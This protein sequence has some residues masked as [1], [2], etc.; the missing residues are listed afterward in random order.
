MMAFDTITGPSPAS[1]GAQKGIAF[2]ALDNGILKWIPNAFRRSCDGLSR[3]QGGCSCANRCGALPPP[4]TEADRKAGYRDNISIRQAEFST[5][6][7]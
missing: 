5:P 6:S 1:R 7:A 4:L 2:E 3:G